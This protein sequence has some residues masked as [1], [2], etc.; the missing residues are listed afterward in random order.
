MYAIGEAARKSG[1]TVETIRYYERERIVPPPD[2]SASGRRLYDPAG[3]ARLRFVRR[4]R[5][6]GLS[7][8]DIRTLLVLRN[9]GGNACSDVQAISQRHL[10]E[11]R[12]RIADLRRLESALEAL[13]A[14]CG[15]GE[16]QCPALRQLF[17]DPC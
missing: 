15:R 12:S 13:I 16:T 5:D 8:A 17:T 10:G 6:L 14:H 2:R 4:C 1:V 3:V 7:I 11:I 9:A